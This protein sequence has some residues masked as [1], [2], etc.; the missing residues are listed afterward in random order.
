MDDEV[1]LPISAL[2][3][4]PYD[5]IVFVDLD[6]LQVLSSEQLQFLQDVDGHARD[7]GRRAHSGGRTAADNR[8]A[9]LQHKN[10]KQTHFNLGAAFPC[11]RLSETLAIALRPALPQGM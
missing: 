6:L 10:N 2:A 11:W 1:H 8:S 4:L 9:L 5:F 3:E 7:D